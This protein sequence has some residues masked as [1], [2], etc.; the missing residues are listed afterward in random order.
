MTSDH[1]PQMRTWSGQEAVSYEAALEAIHGAM[2]AYSALIAHEEGKPA[3]DPALIQQAR[4]DRRAC[5][6]HRQA[7]D[8]ADADQVART[9][10]HYSELTRAVR[11][12]MQ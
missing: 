12:R 3:P 9:R 2:G 6:E 4:A 7:L 1:T 8:P 10:A 11:E 5:I